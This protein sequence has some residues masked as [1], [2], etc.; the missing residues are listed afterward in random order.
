V[1]GGTGADWLN[2]QADGLLFDEDQYG[3]YMNGGDGNDYIN[4]GD[5]L[6]SGDRGLDVLVYPTDVA[7][8][9]ANLQNGTVFFDGHVDYVA[10]IEYVNG[11]N[12]A[13]TLTG[14]G[15]FNFM[16][17]GGGDDT[18]VGN[19]GV[20]FLDGDGGNDRMKGGSGDDLLSGGDGTDVA[21]GGDGDDYC[22]SSESW[23]ACEHIF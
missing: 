6:Y 12:F 8:L 18:L 23:V 22:S 15:Y 3:D 1:Y 5:G 16:T 7:P 21:N 10:N 2:G 13:D 17:G 20:D 19:G 4:G 9:S 14:D 11:T